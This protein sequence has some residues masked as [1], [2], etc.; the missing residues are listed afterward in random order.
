MPKHESCIV[1]SFMFFHDDKNQIFLIRFY[2][3]QINKSSQYSVHFWNS[4]SGA[5]VGSNPGRD[6]LKS[7]KQITSSCLLGAQ[8]Y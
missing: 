5:F 6:N 7:K 2:T 4:R 3:N 1:W 8:Y